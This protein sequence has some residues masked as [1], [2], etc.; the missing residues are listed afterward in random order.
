MD[1]PIENKKFYF[2]TS[3]HLSLI[4]VAGGM[5]INNSLSS[6]GPIL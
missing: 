3:F 4:V 6:L 5:K 2:L 1:Y